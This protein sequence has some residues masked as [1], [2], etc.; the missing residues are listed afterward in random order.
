MT[1]MPGGGGAVEFLDALWGS[2]CVVADLEDVEEMLAELI[3]GRYQRRGAAGFTI[4]D[5]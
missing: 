3:K 5:D 1:L 4:T 2:T